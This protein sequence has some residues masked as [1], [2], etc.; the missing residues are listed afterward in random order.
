MVPAMSRTGF[1]DI[2]RFESI[3]STNRYLL[4]EARR[5]APEGVVAVAEY[6]SAG[7]GRLGRSW[8]APAGANLLASVLI[9]PVLAPGDLH[10]CTAAV[11]LAAADACEAVAGVVPGIKWPNDLMAGGHK[12]AGV[13][14]E[15]DPGAPGGP[16]GSVAVVV[17]IG[18]NVS[19]PGPREADGTSL[20]LLGAAV[21]PALLLEGL[22]DALEPRRASLDSADG[23]AALTAELEERCE[24]LGRRV[25]VEL[26]TETIEGVAVGLNSRGHL[27]VETD[28]ERREVSAGDVVHVRP[29][30]TPVAVRPVPRPKQGYNPR[31][32]G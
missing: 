2:R 29:E 11:A 9:R 8:E 27:V 12:L 16:E 6:Q 21:E 25:R 30:P 26:A 5:G 7:R 13:L 20:H 22:L 10:L 28:G 19:W 24:T 4:D 1:T 17:G 23:R 14:A 15:S 3:D 31:Q 32:V 18:V